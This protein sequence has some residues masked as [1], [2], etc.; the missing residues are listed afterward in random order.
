MTLGQALIILLVLLIGLAVGW[1][2]VG[3]LRGSQSGSAD[4]PTR[5]D[6]A[7]A[8]PSV[9]DVPADTDISAQSGGPDPAAPETAV[10]EPTDAVRDAVADEPATAVEDEPAPQAVEAPAVQTPAVEPT[11]SQT[12]AAETPAAPAAEAGVPQPAPAQAGVESAPATPAVP[13][14]A[15][16]AAEP[17]AEDDLRRIEGVGPK[18]AT[19]LRGA[20][21][22]T[23][24]QLAGTEVA[25]LRTAV[26][27]AGMRVP[28]SLPTWPQQAAVLAA[29]GPDTADVLPGPGGDEAGV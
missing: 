11:T 5:T 20:G 12:P 26:R 16:P 23:Y 21:I 4:S 3:K 22:R 27:D 15:A 7:P 8:Q 13:E 19:A 28:A 14:R 18:M 10:D 9:G 2:I 6:A 25:A 1:L 29:D 17:A 24:R